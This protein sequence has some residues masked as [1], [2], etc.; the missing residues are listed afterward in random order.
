MDDVF[1]L[2]LDRLVEIADDLKRSIPDPG[3]KAAGAPAIQRRPAS[4]ASGQA[5]ALDLGGTCLR[6]AT[7]DWTGHRVGILDGPVVRKMPWQRGGAISQERFL[8]LQAEILEELRGPVALPLGYCFSY[9]S[10]TT[11]DGDAR[12]VAWTKGVS[13]SGVIGRRVGRLLCD[14][15][16]RRGV[17]RCRRVRVVN[18]TVALL[19]AALAGPPAD[20]HLGLVVGTGANLA[21]FWPA[22]GPAGT[23]VAVNLEAGGFRPLH[24]TGSDD[25]VD[26]GS[27]NP[28]DQRF[29]KA[30]S[31]L[32]LPR[33]LKSACSRW[34]APQAD[35]S[36]SLIGLLNLDP[37]AAAHETK[38]ALALLKR[39]AR[40]TAC[41]L[42]AVI[43]RRRELGPLATVRVIAEGGLFWS[44]ADSGFDYRQT[45]TEALGRLLMTGGLDGVSVTV[46]PMAD[47]TLVGSA[48]AALAEIGR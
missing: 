46:A 45:C 35:D 9:P 22:P 17:V 40:L 43:A 7:V 6:A 12:L 44:L 28:G 41:L 8:T 1:D 14:E 26:R 2:G 38:V 23:E 48:L 19:W 36:R 47:A 31:G 34:V 16:A 24:L 15:L 33:L 11:A 21:A 5:R 25:R 37:S 42:A 13:V 20:F 32:Y 27:E 29:E 10:H 18:D 3:V 30:V 39:S 4:I